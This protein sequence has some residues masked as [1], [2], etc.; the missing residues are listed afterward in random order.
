MTEFF[1]IT[2]KLH[3]LFYEKNV[4]IRVKAME[5]SE[6]LGSR[7]AAQSIVGLFRGDAN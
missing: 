5:K 6:S 7:V 2:P 4:R 1:Q 3:T